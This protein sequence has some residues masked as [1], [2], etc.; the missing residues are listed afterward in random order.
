MQIKEE[1]RATPNG[2]IRA[3]GLGLGLSGQPGPFNAITDPAGW[4]AAPQK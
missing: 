4:V 1:W 3:R 2:L